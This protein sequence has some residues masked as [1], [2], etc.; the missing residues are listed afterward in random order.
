[1]KVI[2]V[3]NCPDIACARQKIEVLK[4][5]LRAGELVHLDISDGSFTPY[6]VWG[7]PMGWTNL[8][9]PFGL[10]VHLMVEHP[11]EHADDWFAAGAQ[12]LIVHVETLTRQSLHEIVSAA[13]R[14][15]VEVVLSSKPDSDAEI[16]R[17]YVKNFSAFQVL[18]VEPGPAGQPFLP[19]VTDKIRFL[20]ELVPDATIEVDGGMN[21]ATARLVKD[22][23]ADT[24]VSSNYIFG[25]ANPKTAY[26][27]LMNI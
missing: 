1:M 8:A 24:I 3:I 5:F 26:E 13:E 27:E 15:R 11:E 23:G 12:R 19:I 6:R 4:T 17:P 2:P 10:E 18:A 7:D 14:Y 21:L 22:D 16:F 20:R 9:A 25:A